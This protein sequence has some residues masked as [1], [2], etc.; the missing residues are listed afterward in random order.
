MKKI[1]YIFVGITVLLALGIMA[2]SRRGDNAGV[3]EKNIGS[4][5]WVCRDGSWQKMGS[6]VEPMPT[7]GCGDP[8]PPM[9]Y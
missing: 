4:D 2:W 8:L 1:L 6:P 7:T 3:T 9:T 5:Y